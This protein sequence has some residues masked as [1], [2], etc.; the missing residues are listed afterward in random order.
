MKKWLR[1]I[2]IAGDHNN[3]KPRLFTEAA[4]LV[5]LALFIGAIAAVQG[6]SSIILKN[7][8]FFAEVYPSI[9]ASLT[10][11]GRTSVNLQP[12]TYNKTLEL[13]AK[14]K[15]DDMIARQY[16]AH[17][18]PGGKQPWDWIREAGYNYEYAGE[19][20][21]INFSDSVDVYQAWMNSPGHR[22]NILNK[23]FTEIGVATAK[24]IVDGK[25]S[26]L[27][28]EMFGRAKG[29][30]A[31]VATT[32]P[33][34]PKKPVIEPSKDIAPAPTPIFQPRPVPTATPD[35]D[36][37]PEPIQPADTTITS[38]GEPLEMTDVLSA[39]SDNTD[40]NI[41]ITTST[42]PESE[43]AQESEEISNATALM[44]NIATNPRTVSLVVFGFFVLIINIAVIGFG[45]V[46]YHHHH[47]KSIFVAV[48]LVLCLTLLSWVYV[49]MN[50][51]LVIM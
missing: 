16:F 23:N 2:F 4:A 24:T 39:F 10:N 27:V 32:Q 41:S 26:V 50:K 46:G 13:A 44:G 15:V 45:F 28:V 37:V 22:A 42:V 31:P 5:V 19:N 6:G 12:L 1:H 11:N 7:Q 36:L 25:E 35:M 43:I 48:V 51:G 18:S 34:Q 47:K 21:A 29:S 17:T 30:P 14:H 9:V 8:N 38:Q 20:L 3:F 33:T 49:Y 40:T